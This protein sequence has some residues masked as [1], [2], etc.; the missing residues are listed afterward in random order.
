MT[1][2]AEPGVDTRRLAIDALVRIEDEGAYANLVT[3]AL[4][5]RSSLEPRDR[6]LV[7]DLVYGTT[8]MRRACDHLVDR[9]RR[10]K[11]APRVAAALR[12]GAYQLAFAEVPP[13][14]AVGATVGAA[15]KPARGLVNAILRR[16]A[17]DVAAG[18][19]WPDPSTRLS[20]PDWIVAELTELLGAEVAERALVAMNRPATTHVRADGYVQDLASQAVVTAVGAAPGDRILDLCAAPGGKATGMAQTG[21]DVVAADRSVTRAGLVVDNARQLGRPLPV[22]AADG[23]AAPFRPESFDRVLVDAPCSGLGVL[24][25]RPDA[26]WRVDAAAPSRLAQLQ[27]DLLVEAGRVVAPGGTLV[28]SV[29]TLTRAEGEGVADGVPLHGFTELGRE[30]IVPDDDRDGMFVCRWRRGP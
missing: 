1:R 30:V 19:D 6:H 11:V 20:Y 24:R 18:V 21:A 15:P 16:V 29:C 8:R 7:T 10:G 12:L 22:V 4:L 2:P 17:D 23:R 27:R 14:A 25:R 5:D 28:Y 9:H 13:H 3:N 26:R